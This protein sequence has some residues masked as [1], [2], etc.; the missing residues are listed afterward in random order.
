M[1]RPRHEHT[2]NDDVIFGASGKIGWYL[3][4]NTRCDLR[5]LVDV[6]SFEEPAG[7]WSERILRHRGA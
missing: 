5:R 2:D 6:D 4:L 1:T 3:R 7:R